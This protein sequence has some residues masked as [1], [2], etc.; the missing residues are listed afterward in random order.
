M[1]TE[2]ELREIVDSHIKGRERIGN[3][4]GGS[5]HLGHVSY[6]VGEIGVPVR[7]DAGEGDVCEIAYSYKVFVETEFT[8]YPDNPPHE[9]GKEATVRVDDEGNILESR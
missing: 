9:Y 8:Y 1:F 5:G 2:E 6:E 7:V 3:Q 4:A